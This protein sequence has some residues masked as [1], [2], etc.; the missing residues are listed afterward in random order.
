MSPLPERRPEL[1]PPHPPHVYSTD[2][3]QRLLNATETVAVLAPLHLL[4]MALRKAASYKF[5][6]GRRASSDRYSCQ[7]KSRIDYRRHRPGWR[8]P[9]GIV[10]RQGPRDARD[11]APLVV[12]QCGPHRP[13]LRARRQLRPRNLARSPRPAKEGARREGGGCSL[14]DRLGFGNTAP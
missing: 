11:Q 7:F 4:T 10:A 8:L 13:P 3:L 12:F 14:H 5:S 9:C 1:P 6:G 2:K